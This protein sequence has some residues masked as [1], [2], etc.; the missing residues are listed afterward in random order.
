MVKVFKK[1]LLYIDTSYFLKNYLIE[2]YPMI[3][4]NLIDSFDIIEDIFESIEEYKGNYELLK[5][6]IDFLYSIGIL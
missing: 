6:D 1:Y 3:E 5:E 2:L 4:G